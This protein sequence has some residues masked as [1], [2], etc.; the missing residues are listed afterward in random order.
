METKHD[1][2]CWACQI[3]VKKTGIPRPICT[4]CERGAK[5]TSDNEVRCQRCG[6]PVIIVNGS[7]NCGCAGYAGH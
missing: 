1:H 4:M 5:N 2:L 7:A 3:E 6:H